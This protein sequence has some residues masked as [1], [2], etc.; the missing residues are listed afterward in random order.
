[1]FNPS[2]L[3]GDG[4]SGAAGWIALLGDKQGFVADPRYGARDESLQEPP[5]MAVADG[6]D[7]QAIAFAKGREQGL[8]EAAAE[9]GQAA[10][11]RRRLGSGLRR[12]DEEMTEQLG[13]ELTETIAALCEATLAP[14]ALDH[15]L[16]AGR[17]EKAAALLGARSVGQM[18]YLHPQDIP[19]LDD[20]FTA[21]W[22][23]RADPALER[24]SL[25]I[26][27][28]DGG[29]SDGPAQWRATLAEGLG[30]C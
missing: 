7:E 8:A 5:V 6:A 12:M 4:S 24:G 1:M 17:C 20:D 11:E 15:S 25:R 22:D 3:D 23:I 30:L 19:E 10:V 2:R 28:A 13:R 29:I 26:E 27:S 14:M 18:L 16:L 9:A 21:H